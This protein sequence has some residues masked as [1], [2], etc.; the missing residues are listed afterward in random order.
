LLEKQEYIDLY[1][2]DESG[3]SLNCVIP[4]CWQFENENIEILPQ[5]GETVNVLGFMNTQGNQLKTFSKEGAIN[6]DFVIESINLFVPTLTKITVL[7]LD[8]ARIHHSKIFQ[9][10]MPKWE[11]D[12]LY[13]FYLPAYSPHLNRIETLWRLSKYQWIRPNDYRD[14]DTLKTALDNIWKDFGDKYK[15]QFNSNLK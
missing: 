10:Q 14:L 6:A 2:G 8:N 15:I 11:N 7:V 9:E 12:G 5:K 3:F 4:Y 1:Y 13:I